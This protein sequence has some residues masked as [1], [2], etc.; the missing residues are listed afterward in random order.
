MA[1]Q[2]M[3][4]MIRHVQPGEPRPKS[5][6]EK[7]YLICIA[8]KAG[9]GDYDLWDILTGRTEAYEF[10][11]TNIYMIDF[12][13]SFILVEGCKFEERKSIYAFTKYVQDMYQDDF[14]IDEYIKG[15]WS[16]MDYKVDND[17][18]LIIDSASRLS[19]ESIMDGEYEFNTNSEE[20]D[21]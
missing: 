6:E 12:E 13:R 20:D 10:I 18:N 19:M 21:D 2:Q 16:E 15:D 8:A 9:S 7:Q 14:D 5:P 1:E 4:R 3:R 11:K 17:I